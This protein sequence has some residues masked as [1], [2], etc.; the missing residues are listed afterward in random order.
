M[1]CVYFLE[2]S[3]EYGENNEH[4]CIKSLGIY[5]SY[6]KANLALLHYCKLDGFSSY[7]LDSFSI[8]KFEI[9]V[10]TN[11]TDGFVSWNEAVEYQKANNLY[12]DK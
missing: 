1:G 11:W 7:P 9:D 4:E 10:N 12:D 3:Y 8:Q 5:S 2:H 6:E